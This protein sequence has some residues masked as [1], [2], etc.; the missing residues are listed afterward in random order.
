MAY[1]LRFI[2][3]SKR[4]PITAQELNLANIRLAKTIQGYSFSTELKALQT[5]E[6]IHR[7]NKLVG[8][9]SFIDSLAGCVGGK[10]SDSKLLYS[11]KY[12]ADFQTQTHKNV[13]GV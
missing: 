13:N 7:S 6:P 4:S 8:L 1:I 2:N 12:R 9:W 11:T 10:L 3:N 5:N